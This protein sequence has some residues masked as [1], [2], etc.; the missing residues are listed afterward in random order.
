MANV[1][2]ITGIT[3]PKALRLRMAQAAAEE[4]ITL[5]QV[6]Q[7]ACLLYLNVHGA[8]KARRAGGRAGA[9]T[10]AGAAGAGHSPAP[11]SPALLRLLKGSDGSDGHD[12]T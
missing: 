3:I 2:S 12:D 9:P 8:V 10:P 4:G 11:A 7:G 6:L 5:E 1:T